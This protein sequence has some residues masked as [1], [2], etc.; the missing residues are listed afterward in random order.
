[1]HTHAGKTS[2]FITFKKSF[3]CLKTEFSLSLVLAN[4]CVHILNPT[5]LD[6]FQIPQD[7]IDV[8]LDIFSNF[9]VEN[10]SVCARSLLLPGRPVFIRAMSE[11]QSCRLLAALLPAG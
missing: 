7:L 6:Q 10:K 11:Q 1:M 9:A 3:K 2:I 5:W 4:T 8:S